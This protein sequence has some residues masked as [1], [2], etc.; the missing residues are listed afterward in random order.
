MPPKT[1]VTRKYAEVNKLWVRFPK[2]SVSCLDSV[3][4]LGNHTRLESDEPPQG[5]ESS[6][7]YE[8]AILTKKGKRYNTRM[9]EKEYIKQL[10]ETI[11]KMKKEMENIHAEKDAVEE[12]W[13]THEIFDDS[14]MWSLDYTLA[15]FILPRLKRLREVKHGYPSE[16]NSFEEWTAILDKMILGFELIVN[17][18]TYPNKAMSYQAKVNESLK[19]FAEYFQNLWD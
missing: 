13:R 18:D 6:S 1:D 9:K 15:C 7:L 2:S 12:K 16:L 10:E 14:E 19:L 17:D 11:E 5:G 3:D 8:S 4:V